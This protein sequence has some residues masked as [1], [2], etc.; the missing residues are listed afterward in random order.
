MM[1]LILVSVFRR[2]LAVL[3]T[4]ILYSNGLFW[5][6]IIYYIKEVYMYLIIHPLEVAL[7]VVFV[8]VYHNYLEPF[9]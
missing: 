5:N 4:P 8:T 9:I 6:S 1:L 3:Q 2:W 7:E